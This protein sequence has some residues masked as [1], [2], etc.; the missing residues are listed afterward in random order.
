M[1][2]VLVWGLAVL[3]GVAAASQ[4]A[5]NAALMTRA[6][7]GAALVLNTA[8]VLAGAFVLLLLTSGAAGL[9]ALPGAPIHHYV[10][11]L[12]GFVII[13]SMT[14]AFPR[15]GAATALSF[16]VLG[17]GVAALAIDH[18][19]LW[20]MRAVAL[21]GPRLLGI[22]FLIAGVALLRR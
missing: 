21:S 18:F 15:L 11:G 14:F 1:M 22:A 19:G 13:A 4:A 8:I 12:A 3:A 7:I 2:K 20:G 10:G 6:G 9:A 5:A 16:M 17:Q